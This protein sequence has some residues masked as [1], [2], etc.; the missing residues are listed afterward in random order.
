MTQYV[1]PL[2]KSQQ[3]PHEKIVGAGEFTYK[4]NTHWGQLDP[5][6]FPVENCHDLAIDSQGRII[7]ITDNVKNNIIIY[8]PEGKLLEAWGTE[9]PGAHAIKVVNENGQDY[10]YVVDSGW[11]VNPKWD[12]VSTDDWD[13]PTNKVVAQSGFIAKLSIEGRLI[14]SVG[15]P[16]TIGVYTP[17]QPF[18]PTDIAIANNGDFYVT[19]GYGSDYVLQY[20]KQGQY[21]RHWGGHDNQ[22]PNLNLSNTHGIA[23]DSRKPGEPKLIISSRGERALKIFSMTGEYISTIETPGAYI[24]GPV[25]DGKFGYAPVCWSHHDGKNAEDSGFI[26]IL[27]ENHKVVANIGG[28][29]PEYI[30]GKLQPM[31]STWDLFKHCHGVCIDEQGNVYVGQWRAN[32]SYPIKLEKL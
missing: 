24:G 7:M 27:D 20:N 15:H 21:I 3:D 12:G 26:A 32:Q 16:Q 17:E 8:S 22:D 5:A 18:R 1:S 29:Q 6:M 13:S 28:T 9:F 25:L 14:F 30:D 31:C 19:D 2:P 23:I 4:V 11:L 10:L